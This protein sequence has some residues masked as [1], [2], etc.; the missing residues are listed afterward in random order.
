[1]V[2]YPKYTA[3]DVDGFKKHTFK[4]ENVCA[5]EPYAVNLKGDPKKL[6]A[7]FKGK[8]YRKHDVNNHVA[9]IF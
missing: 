2:I 3:T 1:M 4:V 9:I 8:K 7:Y 5:Q 6:K